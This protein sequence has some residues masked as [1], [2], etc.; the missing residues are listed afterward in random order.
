MELVLE[1]T[2]GTKFKTGD[3]VKF[4]RLN[5]LLKKAR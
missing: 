2:Y 4:D 3:P 5:N 1:N